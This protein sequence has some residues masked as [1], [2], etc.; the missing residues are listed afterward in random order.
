[1]MGFTFNNRHS[2]E[3]PGLHFKTKN[4]PLRSSLRVAE[5]IIPGRH[6]SIKFKNGFN[7]KP[8]ELECTL[9]VSNLTL[10]RQL[11][12]EVAAWLNGEGK[13]IFDYELDKFYKA[14]VYAQ[15]DLAIEGVTDKFPVFFVCAPFA[16]GE[17]MELQFEHDM[18][19]IGPEHLGT[20]ESFPIFRSLFIADTT[21]WKAAIDDYIYI[22]LV[23]NFK[24]GDVLEVDNTTGKIT[25][26]EGYGPYRILN[27][28]D[29]TNSDFFS[30]PPGT[31]STI[32]ITPLAKCDTTIKFTPR[33]L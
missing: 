21:E 5:K 13:L 32:N 26:D 2:S 8:I 1:M 3:F 9:T 17:E 10:R 11:A 6:G 12:R 23:H 4:L 18:I 33:W 15:I 20:T 28:L 25:L 14:E 22:R 31:V 30:I 16:Y 29:W 7:D 24:A 27:K 19:E